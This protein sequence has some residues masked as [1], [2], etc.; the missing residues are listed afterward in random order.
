MTTRISFR[1]LSFR[2][3]EQLAC[4]VFKPFYRLPSALDSSIDY[5]IQRQ[6]LIPSCS[7]YSHFRN[8]HPSF[9]IGWFIFD[10]VINWPSF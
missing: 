5:L 10:Q 8:H 3:G 1:V 4:E 9:Y 7:H 2:T 6:L